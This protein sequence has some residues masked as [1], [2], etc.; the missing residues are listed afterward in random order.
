MNSSQTERAGNERDAAS[1]SA[2]GIFKQQ[3]IAFVRLVVSSYVHYYIRYYAYDEGLW[4]CCTGCDPSQV[5]HQQAF[6]PV[7]G[8]SAAYHIAKAAS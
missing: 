3:R 6:T 5:G 8:I 1:R 2:S 4:R 7:T